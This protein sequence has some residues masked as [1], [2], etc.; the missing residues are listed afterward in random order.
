MQDCVVYLNNAATA[1]P[2]APGT[3]EAT[4]RALEQIPAAP[5]RATDSALP[6]V[7]SHCRKHLARLLG[8]DPQSMVLTCS[9]TQALNIALLGLGLEAGDLVVTSVT[10]HN[11]VLRP[12]RH[13][14]RSAGARVEIIGLDREG[15]LDDAAFERALRRRPR[16]VALNHVSNV[17]GRI[18]PVDRWFARAKQSGALTLL[19]ATQSTGHIPVHVSA[20][21][22]DLVAFTGHKGLRGPPGTGGLY[23]SPNLVLEQVFVGGTGVRSDLVFHPEEMP[24]RLEAGTPNL[25]ALAGLSAALGWLEREGEEKRRI[26]R[27][28][29]QTLREGLARIPGVQLVDLRPEGH[30]VAIVSFRVEGWSIEEAGFVLEQSF[31]IVCR[32]GLHCAPLMH[33]A[34][35]SAPDGTIR[36]SPSGFN[37]E[38]EIDRAISAVRRMAT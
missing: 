3:V 19:D 35:E 13:L 36:F 27:E 11:S 33:E 16:L 37:T 25:P 29:G 8:A 10:E 24:T 18:N 6:E 15:E 2:K 34:V 14:E 7:E 9:A 4:A 22:A 20:L 23:V 26:E 32:T 38:E 5:G 1:W 17:T 31:G 28:L 12:L 30:A 21:N